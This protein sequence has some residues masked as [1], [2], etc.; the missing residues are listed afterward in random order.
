[1]AAEM[2]RPNR[3]IEEAD[4]RMAFYKLHGFFP[5]AEITHTQTATAILDGGCE[6][7]SILRPCD[8]QKL[9]QVGLTR[10]A[11]KLWRDQAKRCLAYAEANPDA[12]NA[13][14]RDFLT[15]IQRFN[16]LSDR[17]RNCLDRCLMRLD[18][19]PTHQRHIIMLRQ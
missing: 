19:Q 13:W 3:E 6:L 8:A 16:G 12:F 4:R 2:E 15:N 14:E 18:D 10:D 9:S 1:M 7:V 17:Q 11:N 5:P